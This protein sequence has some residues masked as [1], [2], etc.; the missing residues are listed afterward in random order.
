MRSVRQTDMRPFRDSIAVLAAVSCGCFVPHPEYYQRVPELSGVV[1]DSGVPIKD[2]KVWY[3]EDQLS[4][5]SPSPVSVT[6]ADGSFRVAGLRKFRFGVVVTG[7]DPGVMWSLC[8]QPPASKEVRHQTEF[9][10][11]YEAPASI[12]F[13]CDVSRQDLC[14]RISIGRRR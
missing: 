6:R 10:M 5:E 14:E 8:I 1:I 9:V 2:A 12:T 11:G 7:G 3:S 4:C 13:R